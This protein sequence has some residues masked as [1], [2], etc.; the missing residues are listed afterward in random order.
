MPKR[1]Y[2][3]HKDNTG[4]CMIQKDGLDNRFGR[5]VMSLFSVND[6]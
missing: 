5:A 6:K 3:R 1:L 2:A 4:L